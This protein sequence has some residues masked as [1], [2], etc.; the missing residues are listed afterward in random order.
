MPPCD[1][2]EADSRMVVHI[3]HCLNKGHNV[4]QVRTVDTDVVVILIGVIHDI[5]KSYPNA[6]I[7]V[8]FG[9]DKFFCHYNI[10]SVSRDLGKRKSQ[11]LPAFHSITGCDTTSAFRGRGKTTAWQTW[12]NYPDVT[13]AFSFITKHPFHKMVKNSHTFQKLERFV[14][15]LYDNTSSLLSVNEARKEL[16]MKDRSVE[17]IPPTQ[18]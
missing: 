11:C 12:N 13:D 6:N 8:A 2:E 16:F 14:I 18:V 1:H 10:N 4:I 9:R 3:V 15:V 7:W 5:Q 17:N